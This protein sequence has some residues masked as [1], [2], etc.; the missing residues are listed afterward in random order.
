M[1]TACG[2]TAWRSRIA[3]IK[4]HTPDP[5]PDFSYFVR[6]KNG[7]PTGYILEVAA[8]LQVVNAVD[9]ISR[10]AMQDLLE[11]WLAK[12]SAAGI[13]TVYDAGVPPIGEDQGAI[14][15]IYTDLE[16]QKRLPF[17]VVASFL[18]NGPPVRDATA[19]VQDLARRIDT[20]LVQARFLKVIGDGTQEGYTAW[21]LEPYADRPDSIGASPFSEAEWKSMILDADRAGI[22]VH[23]HACGER[24]AR[25]ALDAF[26]AAIAANPPR[27][28]RHNIAHNVL[29][30]D[31]DLQRFGKLGVIAQF[32][33]NWMTADADTVEIL[34]ERYGPSRQSQLYR[35]KSILKAG[36]CVSFGTDWPAA[37][38]F[39]T[40]KPL[41]SIQIA[42]TRQQIG[43]PDAPVLAPAE[44][45]FD[46][47]EALYASTMA[48]AYQLRLEDK[49]GS[50]EQGKRADLIVLAKNLFD[51]SPHDIASTPVDM[52][53][54]NGRFTR[55][56]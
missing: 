53:M 18:V 39:S 28:R 49:I 54:M 20:E 26:E 6:D 55:G 24:T 21:L 40:Y 44:E 38:Y 45:R 34:T 10:D 31:A 1:G 51:V 37:G 16:E 36:G 19:S 56:A 35:P 50:I 15:S 9:P 47:A 17:R 23:V 29:T 5:I 48:G 46:L 41:N 42:M 12:A 30:D 27:D 8:I 11:G 2:R 43:K 33:A 25:V 52:T 14:L 7:K 22:D 3:G 4:A 32:S 13:T